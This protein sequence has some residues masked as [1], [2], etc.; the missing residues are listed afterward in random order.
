MKFSLC[1]DLDCEYLGTR[2][3]VSTPVGVSICID[4]VYYMCLVIFIGFNTLVYL[5]ILN[6]KE[7]DII[8]G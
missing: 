4:Q 6:M 1:W 8:L 7:F 2:I 5:L 3:Y